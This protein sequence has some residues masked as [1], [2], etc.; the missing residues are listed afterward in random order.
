VDTRGRGTRQRSRIV[1]D[2]A[3]SL[4]T[5]TASGMYT[6]FGTTRRRYAG[7]SLSSFDTV[8]YFAL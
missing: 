6:A 2:Q 4:L 5:P 1:L 8:G 3:F 7:A